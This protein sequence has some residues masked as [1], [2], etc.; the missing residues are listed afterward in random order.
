MSK[1]SLSKL[2]AKVAPPVI[3]PAWRADFRHK[4]RLPDIKPVRTDFLVNYG[5]IGL[6]VLAMAYTG[7]REYSY[8]VQEREIEAARESIQAGSGAD[9]KALQKS[10]E[11]TANARYTSAFVEFHTMP[12]NPVQVLAEIGTIKVGDMVI[13]NVLADASPNSPVKKERGRIVVVGVSNGVEQLN[14]N[15]VSEAFEKLKKL[16]SLTGL[17]GVTLTP[18]RPILVSNTQERVID[19]TFEIQLSDSSKK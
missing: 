11:F 13:R 9:R 5:L 7:W 19:F 6:G 12:F 16:P 2:G 18:S 1:L 8:L 14:F 10:G 3:Q 15:Q 17:K 4:D